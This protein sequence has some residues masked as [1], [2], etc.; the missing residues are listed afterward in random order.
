MQFERKSSTT[1]TQLTGR[2]HCELSS[3]V[4]VYFLKKNRIQSKMIVYKTPSHAAFHHRQQF[5][6]IQK[7]QNESISDWYKRLQ[8]VIDHCE[9]QDIT[10]Y[11]LI[12]K[13]V[14]TL[15]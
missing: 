3:R 12:D 5:H 6:A 14:S 8:K 15:R 4:Y 2:C 1:N 7:I 13:F 9:F 10:D 11:M